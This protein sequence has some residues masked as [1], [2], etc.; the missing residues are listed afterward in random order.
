MTLDTSYISTTHRLAK[1]LLDRPDGF[2]TAT[3]GDEEYVVD[4]IKKVATH[5]NLD[6]TVTHWTLIL[7]DGGK[8][9]IKR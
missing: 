3:Q 7:R 5:A 4:N 2:L 1:E 6:D 8:G 9:N